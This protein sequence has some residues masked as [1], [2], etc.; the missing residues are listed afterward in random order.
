MNLASATWSAPICNVLSGNLGERYGK[1]LLAC[2]IDTWVICRVRKGGVQKSKK[3]EFLHIEMGVK[4]YLKRKSIPFQ[5][6]PYTLQIT[7]AN[8]ANSVVIVACMLNFFTGK[9]FPVEEINRLSFYI[10]KKTNRH[11]LGYL[12]SVSSFGGLIYARREF[13]FLKVISQLSLKIPR[14]F[15]RNIFCIHHSQ[16]IHSDKK[17]GQ[18]Y[19]RNPQKMEDYLQ[20]MEK[21]TRKLVVAI[22]SEQK[23]IFKQ[24]LQSN[25]TM[26]EELE[27][28]PEGA[29]LFFLNKNEAQK[30]ARLRKINLIPLQVTYSGLRQIK[31]EK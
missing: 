26:Y 14:T 9:I 28:M 2:A 11:E 16:L 13:E 15:L 5:V 30:Y 17:F 25:Q 1:P 21:N 19:N 3:P 31:A 22:A 12:S 18:L 20:I 29:A 27:L 4:D 10:D 8:A 6:P 24:A 7:G 23:L